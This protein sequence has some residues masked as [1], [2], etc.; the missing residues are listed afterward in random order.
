M[1]IVRSEALMKQVEDRF[2][3]NLSA[4]RRKALYHS[5]G[6]PGAY[7]EGEEKKLGGR[8]CEQSSQYIT[9][10]GAQQGS[11]EEY[12]RAV[13]VCGVLLS[14]V[15]LCALR[16]TSQWRRKAQPRPVFRRPCYGHA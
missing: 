11:T 12:V 9:L 10:D 7:Q 16:P 1:F 3:R 6:D 8:L 14:S 13:V 2:E 4:T 5:A 15:R